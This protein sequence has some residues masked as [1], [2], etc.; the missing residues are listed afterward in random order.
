[1]AV[2]FWANATG[3][4]EPNNKAALESEV[5]LIGLKAIVRFPENEV[6][7]ILEA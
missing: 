6:C 5:R 3:V 4:K 2:S 1:M 7:I